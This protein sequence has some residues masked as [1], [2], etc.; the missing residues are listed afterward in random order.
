MIEQRASAYL[1]EHKQLA[2]RPEFY[3]K[4]EGGQIR[5]DIVSY[6]GEY[7]FEVSEFEYRMGIVDDKLVDPNSQEH[8]VLKAKKAIETRKKLNLG[9]T[10]EEAELEGLISLERQIK[11]NPSGTAIW[12]SPP[13]AKKDGYEGHGFAYTGVKNGNVLKMT[14]IRLE[15]PSMYD[16]NLIAN[17][18]WGQEGEQTS[19]DFLRTPKIIDIPETKAREFIHGVFE[20][21]PEESKVIFQKALN[22]MDQVINDSTFILRNGSSEQKRKTITVLENVAIELKKRFSMSDAGNIVFLADYKPVNLHDAMQMQ[23]Y[24]V[25]VPAIGGSCGMSGKSESPNIFRNLT[26]S[27]DSL[28]SKSNQEWFSCPKCKYKADGPVGDT[29][30]GCR[31]TKEDFAK[32][33]G[34]VC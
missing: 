6:L 25:Q 24:S 27:S 26:N 30:P 33:G 17:A 23:R 14:A 5:D 19:E 32:S 15:K 18:M 12:F 10:R 7:R 8:M 28:F 16:F 1:Q 31:L 4:A 34:E 11:E 21:K 3:E 29:C 20:V 13:G 2:F 9:I 22:K